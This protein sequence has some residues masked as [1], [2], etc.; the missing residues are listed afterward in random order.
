MA[1]VYKRGK[2]WYMDVI[3]PRTKRRV[4]RVLPA[5]TKRDAADVMRAIQRKWELGESLPGERETVSFKTLVEEY[6]QTHVEGSSNRRGTPHKRATRATDR[7][8]LDRLEAQF[9][10]RAVAEIGA[11]E[12][13][14]FLGSLLKEG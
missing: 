6:W 9:G 14:R 4:R 10:E 1:R 2:R 13:S 7:S 8:R 3:D 11:P 5:D 12:S